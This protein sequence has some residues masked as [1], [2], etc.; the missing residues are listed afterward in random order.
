MLAEGKEQLGQM[1]INIDLD[2][3]AIDISSISF[4]NGINGEMTKTTKKVYP[5][6]SCP[7]GS[8]K[9]LKSVVVSFKDSL[10]NESILSWCSARSVYE[11]GSNDR[12]ME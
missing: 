2:A 5:N 1:G 4:E 3:T 10:L 7:C 9:K 8:G 11:N 6:D 12:R